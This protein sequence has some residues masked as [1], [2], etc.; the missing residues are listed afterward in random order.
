MNNISKRN[1]QMVFHITFRQGERTI[2]H[3]SRCQIC[4][5]WSLAAVALTGLEIQTTATEKLQSFKNLSN[6]FIT[7]HHISCF[8]FS[9]GLALTISGSGGKACTATPTLWRSGNVNILNLL[10][11]DNHKPHH[12]FSLV[13]MCSLGYHFLIWQVGFSSMC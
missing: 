2:S 9:L 10:H 6:Y 11:V 8:L 1:S 3:N 4:S 7:S 12:P 5:M 13:C